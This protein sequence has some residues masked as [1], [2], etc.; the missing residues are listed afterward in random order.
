[1]RQSEVRR[2]RNGEKGSETI[3]SNRKTE[4]QKK[5]KK[6]KERN[7]IGFQFVDWKQ[8]PK[9]AHFHCN[10]FTVDAQQQISGCE[11]TM[12][13]LFSNKKRQTKKKRVKGKR[14]EDVSEQ[15][16][17]KEKKKNTCSF[18]P[19]TTEKSNNNKRQT[20]P[21]SKKKKEKRKK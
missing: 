13:D 3:Q 6:K 16:I 2:K 15:S 18:C 20:Y 19:L 17:M 1:M 10:P 21:L 12:D 4:N 14:K 5:G 9:I 11:V 8:I 7:K